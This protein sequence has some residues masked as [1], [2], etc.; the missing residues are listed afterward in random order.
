MALAMYWAV[1]VQ[2]VIVGEFPEAIS[3]SLYMSLSLSLYIYIYTCIHMRM[4]MYMY[5]CMNV[6]LYLSLDICILHFTSTLVGA[7]DGPQ[8]E[9]ERGGEGRAQ[10][11]QDQVPLKAS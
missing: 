9:R 1:L 7:N 2:F 5:V 4:W 8:R 3:L 6:Y 10:P 11:V